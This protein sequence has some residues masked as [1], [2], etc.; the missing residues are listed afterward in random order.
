VLD[1]L[2]LD[3]RRFPAARSG[4]GAAR[5]AGTTISYRLSEAATAR[6][7]V[8]R[9]RAGR[10]RRLR[11]TLGQAGVAGV[12]RLAFR[13]R[14]G[15]TRLRPGRYR[16]RAVATDGAANRSQRRTAGFTIVR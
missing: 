1:Q 7:R 12:N 15:G 3:P 16:L 2:T 5:A 9:A 14:V 10:W 11:G 8:Q 6:F 13:G 4:A